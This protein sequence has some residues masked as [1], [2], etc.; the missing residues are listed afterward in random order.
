MNLK[1]IVFALISAAFMLLLLSCG[2]T[3]LTPEE[4]LTKRAEAS[5]IEWNRGNWLEVYKYSSQRSREGCTNGEFAAAASG[6]MAMGRA[7]LGIPEDAKLTFAIER[8]T[9]DG[10]V[11]HVYSSGLLRDGEPIEMGDDSDEGEGALWVYVDGEWWSEVEDLCLKESGP[12]ITVGT[13]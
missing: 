9:V 11:G 10:D 6:S 3:P 12:T 13:E 4:A 8:V 5:V 1:S 2:G 7:F